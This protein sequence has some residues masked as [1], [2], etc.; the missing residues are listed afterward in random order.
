M[1]RA[2]LLSFASLLLLSVACS[3]NTDGPD[4]VSDYAGHGVGGAANTGNAGSAPL[5]TAGAAGGAGRAASGG[6]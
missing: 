6:Q 2:P 1:L 4:W 3:S 5:S